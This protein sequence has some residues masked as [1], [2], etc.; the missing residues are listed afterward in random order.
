MDS[1]IERIWD[2][3]QGYFD[4]N[5][6]VK[7]QLDTYNDFILRKM[8]ETIEGFNPIEVFNQYLPEHDAFKMVLSV[9]MKNP[10][11]SKPTIHEKDGS[12]KIMTPNDARLRNF[13]YAAPLSVDLELSFRTFDEETK[14][15]RNEKKKL[16][17]INLGKIPIMVK[18]K[19]CVLDANTEVENISECRRDTG[20]YFIINGNEKVVISQ[21]RISE[22]KTFVFTN[23]KTGTAFSHIAEIRSVAESR[24]GVPKTTT[25]KLSAK[26]NHFG[27]YIR[28]NVHHVKH[29]VPLFILFKA[30]GIESDKQI[31]EYICY[32]VTDPTNEVVLKE[33]VGSIDEASDIVC[34]RDA[35]EYMAKYFHING[36]PREMIT[37]KHHRLN[38]LRNVLETEF[39]PHVGPDFKKKALYLGYMTNKLVRCY[40]GLWPLDDRDSYINKRVDS[41]GVLMANLF[42]QYYGKMVKDMKN[43][44]QKEINNGAWKATGQFA[45][46]INKVNVYKIIKPTVIESGLK[47]A[48]ATGNWGV[49]SNKNKQGVAQVLNRMT[50][51]AGLSHMRRV[52]TP[53]EKSGKL[54]QP[55]KLH[56]TQFG[57]ICPAE[58][59][60]PKTPILMWDGTIRE[61]QDIIVGDYLIDDN[62]D[63]VRVKS[64]CSGVKGMYEVVP[65]KRNFMSYTVT[66]N[67]ILTLKVG[68]CVAVRNHRGKKEISW[69]D[70]NELRYRYKDFHNEDDLN[71]HCSSLEDDIVIDITIEKYLSL[72]EHVRKN[73][74]L[75]KSS[76]VHWDH[77]D[78]ALDPYILGMWLGDG[79]S[80]GYGFAT[81]DRELL[82]KWIEWG[83]EN[84]A[85]ITKGVRYKY[86]IGS[87]TNK[88]QPGINC[89]KSEAAP[90]KKLLAKYGLIKNKHIPMDYLVN[91]RKT[92]LA[93]LA[94]L[95]DTDGSVRANGHEIRIC[96]GKRNYRIISDAE[97]LARSLGF[98][99]HVSV[100][101]CTYS[102]NGEKRQKPYKEL[103]I[104]GEKLY[105]IPTVLP[106]KKMNQFENPISV[107]RCSS[108]LQSS[109]TLI[110]K[111]VQPY[112]GWQLEGSGRFLLGD[113]SISHNTPEGAS[114]GLVKNLAMLSSITIASNSTNVRTLLDNLSVEF[115][116]GT[117]IAIFARG[118]PKVVV[119]GDIIGTHPHPA[120]LFRELRENKMSGAVNVYTSVVWNVQRNELHVNTEG[121]RCVRPLFV[122][123]EGGKIGDVPPKSSWKE[124]VMKGVIEYLDVEESNTSMIAMRPM[125]LAPPLDNRPHYTHLEIHP[126]LMLGVL[127][128][129]I[130]FSD[131][132]QAP[133]NC[134]QSLFYEENVLMADGTHKMIKDVKVGDEVLT[135]N[136][137]TMYP[138]NSKVINQYV[139]TTTNKIYKITTT[140]GRTIIATEEHKFMTS[141]GW[142]EVRDF[143]VTSTKLGVQIHPL[144]VDT[145]CEEYVVLDVHKFS[146]ILR[147]IGVSDNIISRHS[148]K[149][150]D[151]GILPLMSSDPK[152]AVLARIAGFLS[153]DGGIYMTKATGKYNACAF[154]GSTTSADMFE[155]DVAALGF[156]RVKTCKTQGDYNGRP[157]YSYTKSFSGCFATLFLALGVTSGRKTETPRQ[158]VPNWVMHGSL[159]VKREY[160]AGFQ[161]GDGCRIRF[162]NMNMRGHN[163]IC[164]ETSQQIN[165][166][167]AQTLCHFMAQL[168][169]LM[170]EL[171]VES[172][173]VHR[174]ISPERVLYGFKIR[175]THANLIKYFDTIGYRYDIHKATTSGPIVEYLRYKNI[176]FQA[177]KKKIETVRR[178]HDDGSTTREIADTLGMNIERVRDT[179]R[180]YKDGR[181][182][183][184][185][186]LKEN[187]IEAWLQQVEVKGLTMFIPIKEVQE[188]PNCLIADIT[189]ESSNH[190]FIA[191]DQFTVSN[192]AMGKQAIGIYASN[193]RHRFDTMAHILNY[194]QKPIVETKISKLV[195][196]DEMPCGI[197]VMVAI[198][199][200]TGF[201]Q[202][203]SVIMNKSAI[204]RGLFASTYYRTYKEQNNRNHSNGEE[205]FFVK[206]K[207]DRV[208]VIK[209]FNYEKL[210]D[211]GFVP[212]NTFVD[213]G[214]IIIGKCMPQKVD[215]AIVYK[216][217][218]VALKNNEM[219]FIDRNCHDDKYF[220]NVNGDGY[221]FAKVRIR[222]MRVPSIGDK[223]SSR[224]GQKGTIGMV[225]RQEDMPFTKDGIAPDIIVNPHA[226]PSRMTIGQL[227]EC[228]LGKAC[229]M[230]GTYGDA[231]PFTELTVEQIASTL[232][233]NGMERYGNEILY[234]SRTGEQIAT[235]VFIGP[236]FYQR[237]KHMTCDKVHSRSNSGP[238]VLLTR[239]PAEGRSRDG[240][241]RVGEM[242]QEVHIAHGIQSFLKERFMES[243][244][245]YRVFVCKKCG[246][247]GVANP[248]SNIF[249]CKPCKNTSHFKELRIPYA[250]KLLFQEMHTMSIGTRFVTKHG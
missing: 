197:N 237:L 117:N 190:S 79:F 221:T 14:T 69:F 245:N 225:Y 52:N 114:V 94:G 127:A 62:G 107:K 182:I 143:D 132:N 203:D 87:T 152:L 218:S 135:F 115:F 139:K 175:D 164:A 76:G 137:I 5:S 134:Y 220:T 70:K 200:M 64:T 31:L 232:Q 85:S 206:P 235:E 110:K 67:H 176:L 104:T 184:C 92:R 66:D 231:T 145:R 177:H 224:H 148:D 95:V 142:Q 12:T 157:M 109:F 158:P 106:R 96:Q 45:N 202:E 171:G 103:Y 32:D 3:V 44:V 93:V 51:N 150:R 1:Q 129:S 86:N 89:N 49:K 187:S 208:K 192:S 146:S 121:G 160:L 20:G 133:R 162:N 178:M 196:T 233:K 159:M 111:D 183:S 189:T 155:D 242:E 36:Y 154:F 58:C 194:P 126:S 91:D 80:S 199:C 123:G 119:N 210:G 84:D 38:I 241:L 50:Y 173:C 65:K 138:S 186:N 42:R 100:G 24:F 239:Q 53:L 120:L 207:H 23:S 113:M 198:A 26:S 147:R 30:L 72:P 223:F 247:M 144:P 249:M 169:T 99:C 9:S 204:D 136:P 97:F 172:K 116:D 21:D 216:D 244:D 60:D 153:T 25:L 10:V 156:N 16:Q 11:L 29:D 63:A 40:L 78:V 188:V 57:Y 27:R 168:N 55:R 250:A 236:T 39:L 141:A 149:L 33:L 108:F 128:G 230:E 131:H 228:L 166:A 213:A 229:S 122:V 2:L 243:S 205:E 201:N 140:S 214:D 98:S 165:P 83:A 48:L 185:F 246:F 170:N 181:V 61:A 47:Y 28:V 212:E 22:N 227:M 180:S 74:Y 193:F 46:V 234:N 163:Y 71:A 195:Y 174:K 4:E 248:E 125:N 8:E 54:V 112:V 59:F 77:K 226:I 118:A 240:G 211:N 167:Y 101:V 75:F 56:A 151:I 37:N 35:L 105:E 161:G 13:T 130:P 81:A 7:H 209:P 219:G 68:N 222:N 15:V 238:V 215:S 6:L 124:L 34:A 179:I 17:T 217:T 90:L 41:P 82:D 102:V 19:Y 73:M 88:T 43:M 18:S 191:G